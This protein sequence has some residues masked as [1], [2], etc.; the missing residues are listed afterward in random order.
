[1]KCAEVHIT[2]RDDDPDYPHD[3]SVRACERGEGGDVLARAI[4]FVLTALKNWCADSP[5]MLLCEAI[6]F[7]PEDMY[8]TESEETA[9]G[10]A[11][12]ALE[13]AVAAMLEIK[14]EREKKKEAP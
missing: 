13:R 10:R 2:L 7:A 9:E 3:I 12:T 6:A 11:E 5:A 4:C 1:M 8:R 14:K